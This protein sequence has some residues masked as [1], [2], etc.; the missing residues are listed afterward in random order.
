MPECP[1]WVIAGTDATNSEDAF[2]QTA[3]VVGPVSGIFLTVL[4]SV[5]RH[6]SM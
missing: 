5:L 2:V 6:K 1:N 3:V 4:I